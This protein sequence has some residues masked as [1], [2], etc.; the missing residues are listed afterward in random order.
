MKKDMIFFSADGKGLTSTSANHVANIAKEMIREIETTLAEM[1]LYS[2]TVTLIGGDKPNVLNRG[3]ANSDVEN[4]VSLLHRMADA[5]S[6]IAW[7]R[8]AIK[9][10][11]RLLAEVTSQT[12]EEY[13]E[14]NN[15]K[16]AERP[17]EGVALTDD[18]YFASKS[19]DERCRY[20][21]LETHAATLGKALHPGGEFADAR[22]KLQSK[23]QK[24]HDVEG[25]GR[26]TLIYTYEPTA[27]VNV[28]EDVYFLLQA[29]YRDAQ[30]RLNA[31][32][33]EC[34][35]AVE[36]ST[37]SVKTAY[38]KALDEWT[39]ARRLIEARHAE[40]IQR[41]A[42]EISA[43]RICIPQSLQSIYATVSNLGKKK[44]TEE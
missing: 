23:I 29:Q 13:A 5:K 38:N 28:V 21:A 32:K 7:L 30:A 9:A 19:V 11:E 24:P 42:G 37:V 31:M 40:H 20:Y 18:E 34:Q 25:K 41:R 39:N 3:A 1:T 2:T 36:E 4:M 8:E 26:D 16:L 33:H 10:K 35:K 22:K 17:K 27:D 15:I 44:E 12:L 6:L 14:A 43:M